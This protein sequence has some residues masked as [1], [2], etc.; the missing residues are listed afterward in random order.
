MADDA[1]LMTVYPVIP[2]RDMDAS[3]EYYTN[4]LGFTMTFNDASDSGSDSGGAIGY[5]GV[6]RDGVCLHLQTMA[7][8]EDPTMP[9]VRIEVRQIEKLYEEYLAKGIVAPTGQLEDKPWGSKDFGV[10]DLN[11]AAL[12]FFEDL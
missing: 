5:A 1:R 3:L 12:V 11:N 4:K 9:L 6:S 7:E 10:Y 8:D 2:V